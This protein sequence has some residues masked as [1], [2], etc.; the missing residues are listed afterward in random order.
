MVLYTIDVIF[1]V[2]GHKATKPPNNI[3]YSTRRLHATALISVYH[4]AQVGWNYKHAT[5]RVMPY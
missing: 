1:C 3:R 4:T 2:R 5:V